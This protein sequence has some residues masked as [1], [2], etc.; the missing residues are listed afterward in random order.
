MRV[1]SGMWQMSLPQCVL[2]LKCKLQVEGYYLAAC[3]AWSC[4]STFPPFTPVRI[5]STVHCRAAWHFS[6]G[7]EWGSTTCTSGQVILTNNTPQVNNVLCVLLGSFESFPEE[8]MSPHREM[9]QHF[10]FWTSDHLSS[11]CGAR[12]SPLL[13][14]GEVPVFGR[15]E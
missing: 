5:S 4:V 2:K 13:S 15:T 6:E 7:G 8:E 12:R 14:F 1:V 3:V 10:F 9:R 11:L